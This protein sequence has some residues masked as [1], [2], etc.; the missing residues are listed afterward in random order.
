[1]ILEDPRKHDI[2]ADNAKKRREKKKEKQIFV[3]AFQLHAR[4]MMPATITLTQP[5]YSPLHTA[6]L[7]IHGHV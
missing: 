6:S 4:N 2:K 7:L 3:S 5:A 1:M